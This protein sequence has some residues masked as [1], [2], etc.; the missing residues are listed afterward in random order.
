[1]SRLIFADRVKDVYKIY[2]RNIM[3]IKIRLI[4]LTVALFTF[5][6]LTMNGCFKNNRLIVTGHR[7]ASGNAPENTLA[8]LE[9][10]MDFGV[11]FSEIDVQLTADKQVVLLH[12]ETLARTTDDSGFVYH[13]NLADLKKLDAGTWFSPKFPNER[14]PTLAEAI[15]LVNGYMK[16]NIEIKMSEEMAELP[17]KVVEIIRS[18]DF[19]DQCIVTSFDSMAIKRVK[20][21]APEI[22]TGL[23][24][25]GKYEQGVF[26]GDWEILSCERKVVDSTF[27]QQ[28]RKAK[29]KIHVWTVNEPTEIKRLI[30]LN[31]DG[32]IS[33]Y[34][35][36]ALALR[37]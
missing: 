33:D 25:Y 6:V 36:R 21:I 31:V 32:I 28:A 29:K 37:Q 8:S 14:I 34:P 27:V 5:M 17:H 26:Q 1:M 3:R 13:K 16:L 15:E 2:Y 35:E 10:A 24:F 7:G 19:V 30:A 23:I 9:K 4:L 12:D 11:D 18:Y 20:E 22:T